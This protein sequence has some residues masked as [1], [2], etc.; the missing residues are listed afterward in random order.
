[1]PGPCGAVDRGTRGLV[2]GDMLSDVLIPMLD[3][4]AADPGR[5]LPRRAAAVEDVAGA[6]TSW[7]LAT[8]PSVEL[9]RSAPGSSRIGRTFKRM[10]DADVLSDP[11]IGPSAKDGWDSV[12]GVH[13]WQA[14]SIAQRRE[15]RR[16]AG[17]AILAWRI[18]RRAS[19]VVVNRLAAS[20]TLPGASA[21]DCQIGPPRGPAMRP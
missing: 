20:Y 13:E 15:G 4:D 3:L 21:P 10:R 6:S 19:Q 16:D 18:P 5:G 2:A 7:S 12:A 11:R 17:L 14:Q 1:M 8:D 9:M